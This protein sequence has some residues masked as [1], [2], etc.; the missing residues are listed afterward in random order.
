MSESFNV[1]T[2]ISLGLYHQDELVSVMTFGELRKNLGNVAQENKYELLRFCNKLNI[3]VLGGANKLF[4]YF[5]KIYSPEEVV[6]YADRSWTFN[7]GNTLYDKL[8][9]KSKEVTKPN[10]FYVV[11]GVRRNRF[12]FRKDVLVKQGFDSNKSEREIMFERDIYRIYNSG[13][14]RYVWSKYIN[15]SKLNVK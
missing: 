11:D 3:T 5:V 7:N 12:N 15:N 9:F 8:G 1:G 10:Y 2:K 13:N 6:S 4:K 14:L